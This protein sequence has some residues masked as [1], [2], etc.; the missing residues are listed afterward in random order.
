MADKSP[1]DDGPAA[2]TQAPR[3]RT[4]RRWLIAAAVV[5]LLP[6]VLL[7]GAILVAQSEWAERWIEAR[8]GERI[9]REV[10]IEALDFDLAWPPVVNLASLRIGNPAWATTPNLVD[11]EGLYARVAIPPL[12]RGKVVVP[13]LGAAVATAGL[14]IDG[15][16]ATWRFGEPKE[17]EEPESRLQL[18]LV[19]LENGN[20]RFIDAPEKTDL[21]IE[22]SGSAGEGGELRASGRGTDR[23]AGGDGGARHRSVGVPAALEEETRGERDGGGPDMVAGWSV[24]PG[25]RTRPGTAPS[26]RVSAR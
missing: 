9:G 23:A 22:V 8:V 26:F 25:S 7:I 13:Y 21:A 3:E 18:G 19:Y 11:A 12:F 6:V 15:K 16:R 5:L 10:D 24:R 14:E 4:R 1:H 2:S 20:I 17:E